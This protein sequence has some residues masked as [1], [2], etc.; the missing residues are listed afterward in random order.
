MSFVGYVQLG[1]TASIPI[2][3]R[4]SART[5]VDYDDP[6]TVRVYGPDGLLPLATTTG[7]LLDDGAIT[8]AT[9]A[10][11]IVVTSAS[12]GLTDGTYVTVSGVVGNTAANG[13]FTVT[14]V[15]G[16]TF[17]LDGSTGNGSYTSGGGWH[18]TGLYAYDVAATLANGFEVGRTYTCLVQ[19]EVAGEPTADTQVFIVT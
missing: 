7:A 18:V 1:D 12:H 16:N 19:G 3:A 17:E 14:R 4:D 8:G 15:D 13:T 5:P 2:L 11:P 6:P 9:N 10:S